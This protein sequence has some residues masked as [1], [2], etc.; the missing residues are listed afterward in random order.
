[1]EDA[2]S[3]LLGSFSV[4]A[5]A[6]GCLLCASRFSVSRVWSV[7]PPLL[8][9]PGSR[10]CVSVLALDVHVMDSGERRALLGCWPLFLPRLSPSLPEAN[11]GMKGLHPAAPLFIS[12]LFSVAV[13]FCALGILIFFIFCVFFQVTF[14]LQL[15]Q[16][17][18]YI[19]RVVWHILEYIF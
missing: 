17:I 14:H 10:P 1:M 18:G 4:S 15:L 8:P 9:F 7:S 16:S 19:P 12:S 11:G 2:T 13:R 5:S 6:S 3:F